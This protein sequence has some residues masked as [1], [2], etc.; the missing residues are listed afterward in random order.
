M[1]GQD[2]LCGISKVPFAM[3]HKIS[4]PYIERFKSS[5]VFLKRP[6]DPQS[7][8]KRLRQYPKSSTAT[9]NPGLGRDQSDNEIMYCVN[10]TSIYVHFV[11]KHC[12]NL[13]IK[14]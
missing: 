5:Y 3:P 7:H 1:Y 8:T 9:D 2:N 11:K 12:K 14:I 4:Y 6:P 10:D 13:Q